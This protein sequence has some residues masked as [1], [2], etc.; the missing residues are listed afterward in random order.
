MP[1]PQPD[2]DAAPSVALDATTCALTGT[3][4]SVVVEGDG[5]ASFTE[6]DALSDGLAL[7]V[8]LRETTVD[9]VHR[10]LVFRWPDGLAEIEPIKMQFDGSFAA[11][12]RVDKG[13]VQVFVRRGGEDGFAALRYPSNAGCPNMPED[14]CALHWP[15]AQKTVLITPSAQGLVANKPLTGSFPTSLATG[16]LT[17]LQV[18]LAGTDTWTCKFGPTPPPF[19]PGTYDLKGDVETLQV[20]RITLGEK[21]LVVEILGIRPGLSERLDKPPPPPPTSSV[22]PEP[23]VTQPSPPPPIDPLKVALIFSIVLVGSVA[24]I[25]RRRARPSEP[26]P[27]PDEPRRELPITDSE[28]FGRDNELRWLDACWNDRVFVA[29]IIAWGGAGKTA[30]VAKWLANMR[31]D[32]WCGAERH[33]IWS[34]YRQGT[35]TVGSSDTFFAEALKQ[36][37]DPDPTQGSPWEKGERLAKLVREKRTLLVL[38]GVEPMQWGPGEQEGEFKDPALKT[39]IA[40]LAKDNT[41]LLLI[42]SRFSLRELH[43]WL[44][45]KVEEKKLDRLSPEAG[46]RLLRMRGAKKGTDAELRE[47]VEEY[48]GHALA[49]AVLGSYLEDVAEGDIRRRKEIGPLIHDV[50]Y[51]GHAR[52]VME[53]YEPWLGKVELSVLK[54]L[55]LFDRPATIAE[56]ES[57][58][59]RP[60]VFGLNDTLLRASARDWTQALGKLKRIG[61]VASGTGI[62]IDAHPLVRQHY[63]EKFQK[64]NSKAWREGHRRLYEFVRMKAPLFPATATEM[65]PLYVAVVHG[66]IAGKYHEALNDDY[67]ARIQRGAK[68]FSLKL[69][70]SFGSEVAMLSAFFDPPWERITPNLNEQARAFLL[71]QAGTALYA[72][73][74]LH[75][76]ASLLGR[77]LTHAVEHLDWKNASIAA[78][79]LSELEKQRGELHQARNLTQKAIDFAGKSGDALTVSAHKTSLAAIQH[80]LG[81]LETAADLFKQAELAEQ[82]RPPY[83]SQMYSYRGFWYCNLLLD[84]HCHLE[85]RERAEKSLSIAIRNEWLL[86]IA[87]DHLLIGSAHLD[88]VERGRDGE[89]ADATSHIKQ[90]VDGLR[91]AGQQDYIPLGLLARAELH[92]HIRAFADARRD[93][94]EAMTIATRCGFRLHEADAHLGY[95]RLAIAEG[96]AEVA[97][98]QLEQACQM[99]EEMGY[100][101]RDRHDLRPAQREHRPML[102]RAC[103]VFP[104]KQES[105]RP[106]G[107]LQQPEN[108]SRLLRPGA[109]RNVGWR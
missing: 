15:G 84:Q 25:R 56:I 36:F 10:S 81:H 18:A 50:R 91:R 30:L 31:D 22:K 17:K 94:D 41:G 42:T 21:G 33:F 107:Q 11:T 88:G 92:I 28:L 66:C 104:A 60:V 7:E 27:V 61:L 16:K 64:E 87:L 105:V 75:E 40:E 76:G 73:G 96:N 71:H 78:V 68:H 89:L 19:E 57:L 108:H 34:F 59:A 13:D 85:V 26:L 39:F 98:K 52:R 53:A 72:T 101:R 12:Y 106:A 2:A 109:W 8:T 77:A 67:V 46:A 100:H 6:K 51:G 38:D 55:G 14:G 49:L 83:H 3:A 90:A 45:K 5:G 20:K 37:G 1:A 35:S 58:R 32:T 44:G 69:L 102:P 70:G 23:G 95:A 43:G 63:S 24:L 48:E 79:T 97:R 80:F 9:G 86:D 99:V 74:R 93:I 47:A 103:D 4:S 82:K 65:E 62:T 54:L 29:S